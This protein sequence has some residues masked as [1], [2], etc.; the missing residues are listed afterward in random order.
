MQ[1][2]QK[3]SD[4]GEGSVLKVEM[5]ILHHPPKG[6]AVHKQADHE[7]VHL[8]RFREANGLANQTFDACPQRQ[9]FALDFL[10]VAFAGGVLFRVKM[11]RVRPSRIGIIVREAKGFQEHFEFEEDLICA[12]PKDIR[13]NRSRTV[14]NGMP[15]PTGVGFVADV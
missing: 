4:A 14:I 12:A 8:R 3:Q 11:T 5:A 6:I 7:V 10:R 1:R 13:Q 15:E 2:C 9:M